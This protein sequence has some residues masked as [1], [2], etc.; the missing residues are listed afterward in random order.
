MVDVTVVDATVADLAAETG[1]KDK[2]KHTP[3]H[4][5]RVPMVA[6][7]CQ[8]HL[9]PRWPLSPSRLPRPQHR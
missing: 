3:R 8:R 7:L 2:V 6:P 1:L 4:R 5:N 9:H